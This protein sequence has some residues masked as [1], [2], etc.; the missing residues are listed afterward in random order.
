[1]NNSTVKF[2]AAYADALKAEGHCV[3]TDE[4]YATVAEHSY[5]AVVTAPTCAKAGYTTYTCACGDSYTEAGEA[6]TGAHADEDAN[7]K[8]DVCSKLLQPADGTALTLTEAIALAKAAGSSYTTNKF[9]ITVI[10]ESVYNTTYGNMNVVDAEGNKFTIYG[11]YSADG[12]TR[13]DALSTKPVKGDEI[14]VYG[15]LGTYNSSAQMKNGWIDEIVAHTHDYTSVVTEPTCTAG[16]Y[17]THTCS[18]CDHYYTDSNVDALGHTTEEGVCDNCGTEIGGDVVVLEPIYAD[19]GTLTN[20]SSYG[21]IK[22]TSG[23]TGVNCAVQSGG[24]SD[25]NPVFKVIGAN[26]TTKAV[27]L[28]GKKSAVGKLTSPTLSNGIQKLS[29]NYGFM[30]SESKGINITITITGADGQ[31]A[32]K[33]LVVSSITKN[34]AYTFE[35]VL[36]TAITGD[37]TIVITNNCPSN[38]TS[39][40][41]RTS[42]WNLCWLNA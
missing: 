14:T 17:T 42:I 8:C 33:N 11:T 37:F 22:T 15:V 38:S 29:F 19:F 27:C 34:T 13:Y 40:K 4:E 31:S 16:G 2:P 6:A 20:S 1:M 9:Y 12:K 28:N 36:D 25:N 23:W 7:F 21:S 41:D 30:F 3:V 35:W 26:A 32:T 24:S 18:I 5:E 10:I 39:N